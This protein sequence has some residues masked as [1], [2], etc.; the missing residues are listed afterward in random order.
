MIEEIRKYLIKEK[1]LNKENK[2]NVDFLGE[3]P[4]EFS[5]EKLS[6]NPILETYI[7]GSTLRQL[8]FRLVSC[9]SYGQEVSQNI[10]NNTFYEFLYKMIED[11]NKQKIL[12]EISGIEKIECLNDGS[13]VDATTNTA[14]Y[15]ILMRITY[16]A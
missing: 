8:Q 7:D 6:V 1:I 9:E 5:I 13:I 11:K 4:T 2:I 10:Q 15:S 12:P 3:E 16:Y 14:R